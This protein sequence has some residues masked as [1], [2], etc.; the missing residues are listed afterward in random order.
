[1][2]TLYATLMQLTRSDMNVVTIEDPIEY[3]IPTINQVQVNA[4][5]G[6]TFATGLRS[7]LR[8]DPDMILVGEMRDAETAQMAVQSALTGHKVLS[9]LH[10]TDAASSLYRLIDMGIEPFLVAAC[11]TAIVSQRL[12][13]RLCR[14]CAEPYDPTAQELAWFESVGGKP[15]NVHLRG[16]GCGYCSQTGYRS[17]IGIYE[18]LPVTDEIRQL[19]VVAAAPHEL[20][21]LA[22]AQGMRTLAM[23]AA[24]LVGRDMTTIGEILRKL[25]AS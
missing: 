13:R 14:G 17:R 6:I 7:L 10:A 15:K 18:V 5:A 16:V 12:V 21:A 20:G 22:V 11:V 1:T 24:E 25:A 19:L 4:P 8:Q 9:S 23:Q 2:T 3:I